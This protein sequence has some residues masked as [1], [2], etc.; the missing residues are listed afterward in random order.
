MDLILVYVCV[1]AGGGEGANDA[2]I[3]VYVDQNGRRKYRKQADH[4]MSFSFASGTEYLLA[5]IF[6]FSPTL[7]HF[8]CSPHKRF[9]KRASPSP[10]IVVAIV[11]V[12]FPQPCCYFFSLSRFCRFPFSFHFPRLFFLK[13]KENASR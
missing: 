7:K 4:V 10:A 13:G 3:S 2:V 8:L 11:I 9:S 6:P 5:C 1:A 12:F